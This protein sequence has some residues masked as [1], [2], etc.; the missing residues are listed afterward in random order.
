M[1]DP[2][3]ILPATS[4]PALLRVQATSKLA[5]GATT[6]A[7]VTLA[8]GGT[9]VLVSHGTSAMSGPTSLPSGKLLTDPS[10]ATGPV[11]VDRAPGSYVPPVQ[12][13][14]VV[15]HTEQVLRKALAERPPAGKRTLTAPLVELPSVPAPVVTL[16]HAPTVTPPVVPAVPV[17]SPRVP[18]QPTPVVST[19][20][21]PGKG[22]Q[23]SKGEHKNGGQKKAHKAAHVSQASAVEVLPER[24][25]HVRSGR[26]AR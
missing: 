23:P 26:H 15:D 6:A 7:L 5:F 20:E 3:T 2:T 19:T 4:G 21:E 12:A 16:P 14:P 13:P 1:T 9:A 17:H 25:K 8:S 24:A 10:T 22:E 11:V 18:Q